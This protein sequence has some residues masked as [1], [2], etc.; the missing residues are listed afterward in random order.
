MWPVVNAFMD[1]Y[2][3]LEQFMDFYNPTEVY[4]CI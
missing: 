2:P 3:I 1:F 4:D